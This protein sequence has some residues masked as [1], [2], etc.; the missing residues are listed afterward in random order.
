[1]TRREFMASP[2]NYSGLSK[3]QEAWHLAHLANCNAH[4]LQGLWALHVRIFLRGK[5]QV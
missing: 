4:D 1:M 3:R 5:A 2:S